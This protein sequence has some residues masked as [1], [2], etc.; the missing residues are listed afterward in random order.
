M[1]AGW[2]A[3][4]GAI[5]GGIVT[6]GFALIATHINNRAVSNRDANRFLRRY[7]EDKL[8]RLRK[9]FVDVMAK[10]EWLKS[11]SAAGKEG[12]KFDQQLYVSELGGFILSLFAL[13]MDLPRDVEFEVPFDVENPQGIFDWDMTKAVDTFK[14]YIEELERELRKTGLIA[15]GP[16]KIEYPYDGP[17]IHIEDNEVNS[18]TK[19]GR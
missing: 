8:H 14:T 18:A 19:D 10:F 2:A 16:R 13:K 11:I 7:D 6:G 9:S 17:K 15:E 12:M 4:L 3:F 5:I 1:D